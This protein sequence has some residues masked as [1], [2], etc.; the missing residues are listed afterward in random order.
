MFIYGARRRSC[1]ENA[2]VIRA[3]LY[4]LQ[5]CQTYC[6]LSFL[7]FS[8]LPHKLFWNLSYPMLRCHRNESW[9]Q[10]ATP[11]AAC[12]YR[13]RDNFIGRYPPA[14]LSLLTPIFTPFWP[15]PQASQRTFRRYQP[16]FHQ[17][18]R[19]KSNRRFRYRSSIRRARDRWK[20]IA[21][22]AKLC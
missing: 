22:P 15:A 3:W 6:K 4:G 20:S 7:N 2:L 14:R 21:L 19:H 8:V 1:F 12:K 16:E 13:P 9:N 17:P 5:M 18:S 10:T 11:E